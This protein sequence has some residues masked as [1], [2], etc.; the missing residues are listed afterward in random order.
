MKK[1]LFNS[2]E[3]IF[4]HTIHAMIVMPY[5]YSKLSLLVIYFFLFFP[6]FIFF[7]VVTNGHYALK[8][9]SCKACIVPARRTGS[10]TLNLES[11]AS[12]IAY[13]TNM[14]SV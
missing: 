4:L 1:L 14:G 11:A 10:L 3:L 8:A 5:W 13:R 7:K 9:T 12:Q 6:Y 2:S